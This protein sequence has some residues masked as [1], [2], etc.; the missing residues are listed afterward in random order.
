MLKLTVALA[1][2]FDETTNEFVVAESFEL[3][4][5]HSLFSL[6]KWESREEV[7]FLSKAEKSP[8]ATLRYIHDMTVT[9]NVPSKVYEKLKNEHFEAI[10]S[11]IGAAMTATTFREMQ[12]TR[13]TRPE[14]HTAEI[15]YHMMVAL[16]IP[17]DPC[18]HWHL[19][20]LIT[21]IKVC[22]EKN[23]PQ[24]KG[25]MGRGDAARRAA[26]NQQRQTQYGTRG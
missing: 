18:E 24:K 10:N 21:L 23:K 20:R 15:M 1:E 12:P 19:N 7:P 6:A 5:E 14:I 26:L 22:N 2:G 16:Q 13:P 11:Y 3:E 8:A 4:L 25:R 17:F 9:P